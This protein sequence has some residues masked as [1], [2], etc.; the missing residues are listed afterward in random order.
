[1]GGL[2]FEASCAYLTPWAMS[3][4]EK[5]GGLIFRTIQYLYMSRRSPETIRLD[6][7]KSIF[8]TSV[9]LE[10]TMN[11]PLTQLYDYGSSCNYTKLL[12]KYSETE[13]DSNCIVIAFH[14]KL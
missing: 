5:G 8:S 10:V 11:S 13:L 2:I 9:H 12:Q 3:T 6:A 14:P 1:M 4:A 7:K